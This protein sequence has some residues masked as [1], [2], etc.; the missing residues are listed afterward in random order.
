MANLILIF[1]QLR[2]YLCADFSGS[3][4]AHRRRPADGRTQ[5]KEGR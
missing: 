4:S 2:V 5:T 1:M 3:A